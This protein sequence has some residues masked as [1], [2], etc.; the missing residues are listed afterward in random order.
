MM[1][2]LSLISVYLLD[3]VYEGVIGIGKTT[4]SYDLETDFDSEASIEGITSSEI[5]EAAKK[6]TGE[7]AQIPPAHSAVKVG[8][9]RA[10]KLARKNEE[11]KLDPRAITIHQFDVLTFENDEVHFRIHCSKGT[12]IRSI[13][14]DF[15]ELL[16]VG[17]YLKSLRRTEI[18]EY[19]VEDADELMVFVNQIQANAVD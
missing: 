15:G 17:G 5:L 1:F 12:Y 6:L 19:S 9:K 16:G 10:Y 8:G 4:P 18:G 14:R 11:V 2:W 3:K 13:A 7:L